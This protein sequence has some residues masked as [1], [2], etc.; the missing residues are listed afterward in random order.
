M[1]V[2]AFIKIVLFNILSLKVFLP[3][4][5]LISPPALMTTLLSKTKVEF[6]EFEVIN[7]IELPTTSNEFLDRLTSIDFII[8]MNLNWHHYI[9]MCY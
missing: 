2:K 9:Q 8:L 1:P 4:Y 7:L 6:D 5:T 3:T